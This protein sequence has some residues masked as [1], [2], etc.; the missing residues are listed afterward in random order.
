MKIIMRTCQGRERY[1]DYL[2][3]TVPG[4]IV[5]HDRIHDAVDTF[6]LA[7]EIAG[8]EEALHIEDDIVVPNDFLQLVESILLEHGKDKIIQM[9]WSG[10]K[11]PTELRLGSSFSAALCFY[12]P[13]GY[14]KE[15]LEYYRQ[16]WRR[17]DT[18]GQALDWMMAD[19]LQDTKRK[20]VHLGYSIVQH[21]EGKSAIDSRRSS[22]RKSKS[23]MGKLP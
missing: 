8:E 23:F 4:I 21:R 17:K 6:A 7:M 3:N 18:P 1:V 15:L 20:Y 9:Y 2:V 22:K 10:E 12:M 16:G 14:S 13:A 5:A 11:K 19:W